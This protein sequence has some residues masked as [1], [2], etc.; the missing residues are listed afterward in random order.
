[1]ET[2]LDLDQIKNP[3]RDP[4]VAL[5]NFDGVHRGHQA[6]IRRV[7]DRARKRPGTAVVLTFEP[8]PLKVLS[9]GLRL[10]FLASLEEKTALVH[11]LGVSKILC[12][13]FTPAFSRLS[14][15]AFVRT[16]LH[17]KLGVKEVFVGEGFSFGKGRSGSV[18][19]LRRLGG[20]LGFSVSSIPT[21]RL[22]GKVVSSSRIRELLIEGRVRE[23]AALLGRLYSLEG[24]VVPG[25][26]R[27]SGLG[28]PTA[29]LKPPEDRVVPSDGV[30]AAWGVIE[31]ALKKGV[32]YIGTQPTLGLRERTLELHLFDPQPD[33]Y[34]KRLRIGFHDWIR[35]EKVFSSREELVAQIRKDLAAARETFLPE[36]SGGLLRLPEQNRWPGV[37]AGK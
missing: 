35:G 14:P 20:E 22:E 34:G 12:L 24:E 21:V 5:G 10:Q 18:D 32:A 37:G 31:G 11:E 33:L 28:V 19:D 17:E 29:N 15:E 4:V 26:R 25:S 8:H 27:G 6:L 30:Y 36:P 3:P 13:N 1:V 23:A 16:L 2:I 7:V 9:P